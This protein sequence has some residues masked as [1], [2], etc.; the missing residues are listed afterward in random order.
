MSVYMY[1]CVYMC[2][3]VNVIMNSHVGGYLYEYISLY[4]YI[5][6][7]R[8]IIFI[9]TTNTHIYIRHRAARHARACSFQCSGG[10]MLDSFCLFLRDPQLVTRATRVPFFDSFSNLIV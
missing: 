8:E 2:V 10:L 7:Y 4:T 3:Y 9:S 6:I 1:I 5:C